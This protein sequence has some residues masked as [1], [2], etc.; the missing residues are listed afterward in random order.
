MMS[1]ITTTIKLQFSQSNSTLWC[2]LICFK[3]RQHFNADKSFY[4]YSL[5][6]KWHFC[7]QSCISIIYV[8]NKSCLI[9]EIIGPLYRGSRV[10]S[11]CFHL[12]HSRNSQ[13]QFIKM[14]YK[15]TFVAPKWCSRAIFNLPSGWLEIL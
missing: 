15:H 6:N 2:G 13:D 9:P 14:N 8:C 10:G 7:R 1:T 12:V 11:L 4:F 3:K 5:Y